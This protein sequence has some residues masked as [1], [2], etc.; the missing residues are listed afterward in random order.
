GPANT[1]KRRSTVWFGANFISGYRK[2]VWNP[3]WFVIA[4]GSAAISAGPGGGRFIRRAAICGAGKFVAGTAN[5]VKNRLYT[6]AQLTLVLSVASLLVKNP[7]RL[8]QPTDS[9]Y[10]FSSISFN[11]PPR[12]VNV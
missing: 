3:N 5:I 12:E 4:F 6:A 2:A 8:R 9:G 11:P 1:S 10:F 7:F